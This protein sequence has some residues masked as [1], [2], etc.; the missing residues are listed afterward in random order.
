MKRHQL[1]QNLSAQL[2]WILDSCVGY[3]VD[4]GG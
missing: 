4:R 3:S 1:A 2:L